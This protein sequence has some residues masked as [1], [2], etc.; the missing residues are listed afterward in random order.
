MVECPSTQFQ[1]ADLIGAFYR[2]P[3]T[4]K[5]IDS[6]IELNIET[7]YLRNCETILVGDINVDYLDQNLYSKH[8]LAKSLKSMNMTQHVFGSYTTQK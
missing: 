8:R 2:P 6:M 5:E 1:Q 4:S 3:S 7:A